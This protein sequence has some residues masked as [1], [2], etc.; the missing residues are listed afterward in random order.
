M[1]ESLPDSTGNCEDGSIPA[2]VNGSQGSSCRTILSK[3]VRTRFRN[4]RTTVTLLI[5]IH[6]GLL[7]YSS[8]MHSPTFNEPAHFVAGLSHVRFGRFDLYPVNPPLVR[9]IA[10]L[11]VLAVGCQEDWNGFDQSLGARPEFSMGEDFVVADSVRSI[12]L[13]TIARWACIQISLIGGLFCFLWS[14]ELWSSN[15]AGLVSLTVW[16]FEPNNLAH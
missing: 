13:F 9:I 7:A 10:A 11:P 2:K 1:K 6:G 14:R 4:V 3:T 16:C 8:T 12:W 15:F 5:A